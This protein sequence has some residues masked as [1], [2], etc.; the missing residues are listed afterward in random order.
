MSPD[1]VAA[2]AANRN[3]AVAIRTSE[4]A[5]GKLVF[6][7]R[8][9]GPADGI[10]VLMLHGF[11]DCHHS[12]DLQLQAL[13]AAGYR[14]IV[15]GLRGYSPA[16]MPAD[17]D[18]FVTTLVGDII[19]LLDGLG[20]EHCHLVGHDWGGIIGWHAIA[21]HP[22]RFT[23][24]T[25]LAIPPLG[26][27]VQAVWRFPSQL[28]NSWYIF[29]FQLHGVADRWLAR[30]DFASIDRL[31]HS[32]SPGW[33][34]PGAT[35]AR[36]K[37]AFRQ[38][39]VPLAALGYYRH[40]FRWFSPRHR[41]SLVLIRQRIEM[42]CLVLHGKADGALDARLAASSVHPGQFAHGVS[43]HLLDGAGHFLHQEQPAQA[44]ALLLDFLGRH[45]TP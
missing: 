45:T 25:S 3:D 37:E 17:G 16:A 35:M 12:F 27:M 22:Q 13:G 29:F 44:N 26:G 7:V 2:G 40:L 4:I 18:Y 19:G 38:P 34:W 36:V 41:Q 30:N 1:P 21:M 43:F 9:A 8:E 15:P 5:V 42:P 23:T 28:R 33:Q 10:P 6:P 24:Y 14:V 11:P 31:W 32:W 20:I 39:G